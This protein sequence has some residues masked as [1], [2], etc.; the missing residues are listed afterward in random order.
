MRFHHVL[1]CS[2][3]ILQHSSESFLESVHKKKK[4]AASVYKDLVVLSL[5]VLFLVCNLPTRTSADCFASKFIHFRH[6][7]RDVT[8]SAYQ[9]CFLFPKISKISLKFDSRSVET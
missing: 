8:M 6:G 7:N 1:R 2:T 4:T 3:H 9:M 5:V